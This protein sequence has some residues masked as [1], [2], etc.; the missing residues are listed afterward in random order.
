MTRVNI[1]C[2]VSRNFTQAAAGMPQGL[3]CSLPVRGIERVVA[4]GM[5]TNPVSDTDRAALFRGTWMAAVAQLDLDIPPTEANI[6]WSQ[7]NRAEQAVNRAEPVPVRASSWR[8]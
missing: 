2:I 8:E 1:P 6:D 5:G 4:Y 7:Y 3:F